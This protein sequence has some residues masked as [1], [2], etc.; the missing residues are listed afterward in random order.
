MI[1]II[2]LYLFPLHADVAL[3]G[4]QFS[5]KE[6]EAPRLPPYHPPILEYSI[7]ASCFLLI[8][9]GVVWRRRKERTN[10]DL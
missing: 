2:L 8:A 6:Q 9:I 5:K 4:P 1:I 3:P 10:P 7:A